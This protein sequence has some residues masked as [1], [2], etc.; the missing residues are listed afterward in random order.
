MRFFRRDVDMVRGPLT[1]GILQFAVPLMLTSIL[2]LLYNA[3]DIIVMGRFASSRALAAV[4]STGALINL[5]ITVFL[6]LSVGTSVAVA[7]ARGAQ[8]HRAVSETVHTAVS[9]SLISSAAVTALGILA[10]RP[11]LTLMGTPED[12]VDLSVLYMRIYFCGV[13]A[14]LMYNFTSA[15]LRATGDTRRPMVILSLS[16]LLNVGLNL[17]FVIRLH[18]SVDGVALATIISQYLSAALA[19]A[20]LIRSEGDI[21]LDIR[22]LRIVKSRLVIMLRIG[23]PA[24]FQGALFSISNVLIQSSLNSFGADAMAGSSAAGNIEGFVYVAMN[25]LH[26]AAIT[27]SGQNMGAKNYGRIP[28][29]LRACVGLVFVVYVVFCGGIMLFCEPLL[30]IYTTDPAIIALGARKQFIM[31]SVYFFLGIMEVGSGQLRGM[32]YSLMPMLVVLTGVCGVRILW[33]YTVFARWH[34]FEVLFLSYPVSWAI[35]AVA[36]LLSYYFYARKR[37]PKGEDEL[38]QAES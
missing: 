17:F 22:R 32:G 34:T 13:P 3:A 2:Q 19:V 36:L 6:G 30:R 26:Q 23:L 1:R 14:N 29:I 28:K 37:L 33:L 8:D 31:M 16:G 11:L 25:A 10:A 24:G 7:N 27:F 15:V 5:L 9:V 35:T 21:H 18:M 12:V 38:V 20:C 4:G